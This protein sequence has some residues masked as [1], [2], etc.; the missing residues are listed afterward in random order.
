MGAI[1]L[2]FMSDHSLGSTLIKWYD[3]GEFSHVDSVMPDGSLLGARDDTVYG[4]KP[5]VQIRPLSYSQ[6]GQR[7]KRISLPCSDETERAYYKL[8]EI[9]LGRSYN[10]LAILAF[11]FG[12]NWSGKG[13]WF[14]SQLVVEVLFQC[15]FLPHK[16][17]TPAH[18][19]APD[20]LLLI[21]SMFVDV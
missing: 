5:G 11:F 3:H 7:V 9:H 10:R 2:Q 8:L 18:K 14:C 15:G 17:S 20:D 21:C 19:I 12:K 4:I 6:Q 13:T 1:T 16:P